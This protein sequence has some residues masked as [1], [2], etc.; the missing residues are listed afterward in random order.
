MVDQRQP[1]A[2]P[3][4]ISP[5]EARVLLEQGEAIFVDVRSAEEYA[6]GH[7]PGA[8]WAPLNRLRALLA[9]LPRGTTII[10]Y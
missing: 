4:R 8:L 6:N 3:I 2:E 9:K 5:G 1:L 7:I 10:F